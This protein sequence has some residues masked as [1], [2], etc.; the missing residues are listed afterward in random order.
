MNITVMK[1]GGTSV[2]SIEGIKNV[3]DIIKSKQ[4]DNSKIVVVVS[5]MAGVTNDLVEKSES[6]SKN[7]KLCQILVLRKTWCRTHHKSAAFV[8]TRS[9][10]DLRNFASTAKQKA[11]ECH[12]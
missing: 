6:I 7:V 10:C 3:A 1:F 11:L 2:A 8:A 5:A 12:T 4:N 9:T